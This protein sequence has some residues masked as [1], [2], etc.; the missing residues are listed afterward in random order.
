MCYMVFSCFIYLLCLLSMF[1]TPTNNTKV[2]G[3]LVGS[4]SFTSS[5]IKNHLLR[6][7]GHV[8][9]FLRLGDVKVVI[10]I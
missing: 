4:P 8:D 7:V 3:M 9:L 1:N 5:F 10:E 6:N 2:L